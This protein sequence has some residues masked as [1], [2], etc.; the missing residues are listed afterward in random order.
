VKNDGISTGGGDITGGQF[1]VGVSGGHVE[2]HASSTPLPD[3]RLKALLDR[4]EALLTEHAPR[5]PEGDLAKDDLAD[6][7]EQVA[8][9][10]PDRRRL[11]DTLRRLAE[12]VASVGALLTAVKDVARSL[13][14]H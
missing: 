8:R 2:Q 11:T 7:R 12:R 10:T 6:V 1:A 14:F 3:D 13:G 9:P 4:V 5:L